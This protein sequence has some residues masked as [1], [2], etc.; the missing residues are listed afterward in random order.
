MKRLIG[1]AATVAMLVGLT[2]GPAMARGVTT[3][4]NE[5]GR[6]AS[7]SRNSPTASCPEV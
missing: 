3:I 2:A 4:S 1:L 5:Q 6:S 7:R